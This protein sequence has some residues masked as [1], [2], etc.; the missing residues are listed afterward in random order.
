MTPERLAAIKAR[1]SLGATEAGGKRW[2]VDASDPGCPVVTTETGMPVAQCYDGPL[3][4]AEFL[5][6]A[7][8]DVPD[9]VDEVERLRA[10]FERLAAFDW[11]H[12]MRYGSA[13]A[14]FVGDDVHRFA[15]EALHG[16]RGA[17][18]THSADGPSPSDGDDTP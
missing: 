18:G 12:F 7:R 17:N 1:A 15:R 13:G 10:A 2:R 3:A 6:E 8:A 5:A 4:V 11:S 9:L 16:P 14:Q